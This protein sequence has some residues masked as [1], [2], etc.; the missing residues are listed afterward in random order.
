MANSIY[1]TIKGK[2]QGLISQGCSTLDSIGNKFQMG[3]EDQILG[4]GMSGVI[5]NPENISKSGNYV[6]G[7]IYSFSVEKPAG[8]ISN[9]N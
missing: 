2:N 8:Y 4:S 6:I 1:V 5:R 7:V 9:G 3:H